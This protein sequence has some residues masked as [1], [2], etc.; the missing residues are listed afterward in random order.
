MEIK[1]NLNEPIMKSG[2]K[3]KVIAQKLGVDP[4]TLSGWI[5][6]K[7][8]I[9]FIKAVELSLIMGCEVDDLWEYSDN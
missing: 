1:V 5:H 7:R 6:G 2:I 4:N 8:P 3:K 9:P